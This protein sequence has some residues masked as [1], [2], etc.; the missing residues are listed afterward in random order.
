M[1]IYVGHS[2]SID[3]RRELYRP[4]RNS[5]LNEEHEIIL[6]HEDS[7]ELFESKKFLRDE[8]DLMVAEVSNASTGLGI[9]L[10]WADMFDVPVIAVY[11]EGSNFSGSLNKVCDQIKEYTASKDLISVLRSSIEEN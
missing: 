9:E 8:C 6:P 5:D 3:Y 10:G 2:S 4:L 7:E 11:R 1:K